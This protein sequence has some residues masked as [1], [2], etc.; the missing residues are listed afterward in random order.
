M[1]NKRMPLALIAAATGFC[2]NLAQVSLFRLFMGLFYGTEMHLGIFLAIWLGGISSGGLI[3]GKRSLQPQHLLNWFIATLAFSVLAIFSAHHFLPNPQGGFLPFLPVVTLM[4]TSVFPVSF[5]IG[6]LLPALLRQSNLS[7]GVFYSY[8]AV[9]SFFAGVFFS[10]ILGGTASPILCLLS[11]PIVLVSVSLLLAPSKGKFFLLLLL[12]P[13]ISWFG[14]GLVEQIELKYWKMANPSQKLIATKETP[15]QKLQLCSYYEQQSLF[16]NGMLS[17]SWPMQANSEQLVHSFVTAMR[18]YRQI[19]IL[20]APPPDVIEEFIKY[21]DLQLTLVELDPGI[22]E[23]YGYAETI[24]QRVKILI[25]DPRRFLHQTE[26]KFDGIMIYPVSPVTLSGNRL[27]TIEA[28]EAMKNALNQNGVLS[29]Q[30]SGTENYLGSI[31]EQIILS[32]WQ[33]LGSIFP[34]RSAMPGNTITFFACRSDGVLPD[35]VKT[36]MKRFRERKIP[37]TTFMA[38]SFFNILQPF[39]VN[40]LDKWLNRDIIARP[41]TDSH[42]ESFTQQ[43]ELWNIYSGTSANSIFAKLQQIN[44]RQILL[45]VIILAFL[46]WL[47]SLFLPRRASVSA[48]TT[49]GVAISGATGI[50][51]EIILILLYQ[52]SYGAAYQMTAFFFGIYMLGLASG[53]WLFGIRQSAQDSFT[54][55]KLVKVLQILFTLAGIAFIK[56]TFVHGATGTGIAIFTIAFLDGI[57]FPVADR[58]LRNLGKTSANSAGMLLFADNAGALLTGLGS[59]L[60]L[61]PTIGMRGSFI[62]LATLLI[63]NLALLLVIARNYQSE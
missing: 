8:E 52:N 47:T 36:Y 58:I 24:K 17:G 45:F 54:S 23:L 12:A 39:R 43:L 18:E 2:A 27:F 41:N 19:L 30:V 25:D 62:L 40:E 33:G 7:L 37:T 5:F 22:I 32:T 38:L 59:G 42:P 57:E 6:M 21:K 11:L 49:V 28:F 13:A 10:F 60:W 55:L 15:Y 9:G 44:L 16:A 48:I 29:L 4:F 26:Q 35:G 53:A 56:S 31:K 50:L 14:P 1:I 46:F 3:G 20:G 34:F 61:L 63:L 51:C